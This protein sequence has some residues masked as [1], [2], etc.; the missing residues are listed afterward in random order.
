MTRPFEDLLAD[1]LEQ[2]DVRS[3][4]LASIFAYAAAPPAAAGTRPKPG[5]PHAWLYA[6]D[7]DSDTPGVARSQAAWEAA[8]KAVQP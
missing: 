6:P 3:E 8:A 1:P 5:M 7:E 2:F 4:L